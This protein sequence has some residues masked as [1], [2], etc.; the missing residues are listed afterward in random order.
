M[1]VAFRPGVGEYRACGGERF[2]PLT[3]FAFERQ[4]GTL[5]P[6]DL[7]QAFFL[8]QRGQDTGRSGSDA[9]LVAA[10]GIEIVLDPCQP[11][12]HIDLTIGSHGQTIGHQLR[13]AAFG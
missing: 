12:G 6:D 3:L 2:D 7:M 5:H 9:T 13:N 8:G 10:G 1:C 4:P 11:L